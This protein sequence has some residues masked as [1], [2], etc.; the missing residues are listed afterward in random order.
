MA[1]GRPALRALAVLLVRGA[2]KFA[3][4]TSLI[5]CKCVSTFVP[6]MQFG[7]KSR[8]TVV[9][10]F[11]FRYSCSESTVMAGVKMIKFPTPLSS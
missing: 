2:R 10:L 3:G 11:K 7:P 8:A 6:C 4:M 9:L 1:T 5:G